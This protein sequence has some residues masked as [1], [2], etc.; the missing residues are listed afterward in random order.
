[1]LRQDQER[2]TVKPQLFDLPICLLKSR[3]AADLAPVRD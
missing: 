1:V 2:V 3:T